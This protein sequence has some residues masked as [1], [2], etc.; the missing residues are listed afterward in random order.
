[1]AIAPA[2]IHFGNSD[3]GGLGDGQLAALNI[4]LMYSAIDPSWKATVY[5]SGR[6]YVGRPIIVAVAGGE[7][8]FTYTWASKEN[9]GAK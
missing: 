6:A 7:C 1:V 8:V 2:T 9:F 4:S 3:E 5:I